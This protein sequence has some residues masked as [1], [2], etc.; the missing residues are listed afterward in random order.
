MQQQETQGCA[1]D[2]IYLNRS[3]TANKDKY[4]RKKT[5]NQLYVSRLP[6]HPYY[7]PQFSVAFTRTT[8]AH[9]HSTKLLYSF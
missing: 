1:N 3:S 5:G 7:I 9:I 8:H 4:C 6:V 2:A